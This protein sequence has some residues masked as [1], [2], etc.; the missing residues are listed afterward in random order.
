[1]FYLSA[2]ITL[3]SQISLTSDRRL[4][5]LVFLPNSS[6]LY[7]RSVSFPSHALGCRGQSTTTAL[8]VN[9]DSMDSQMNCFYPSC[10]QGPSN[11]MTSQGTKTQSAPLCPAL[12]VAGAT[13]GAG[14][15][16]TKGAETDCLGNK[17]V[18]LKHRRGS[19][20]GSALQ[21]S[22]CLSYL[23]VIQELRCIR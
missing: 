12:H 22:G 17:Y 15:L 18:V 5:D 20:V 2:C 13:E 23:N 3:V 21:P 11:I 10:L 8:N 19:N 1:M 4:V 6:E 9:G 14:Q 16:E 7:F